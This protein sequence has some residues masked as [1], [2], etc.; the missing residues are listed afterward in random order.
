M[1]NV[2]ITGM[3]IVSSLGHDVETFFARMIAGDV[4]IEAAPWAS[5][6]GP[7]WWSAVRDFEP[8]RW[9]SPVVESGTDLYAQYTLAAA[10]QC[11]RASGVSLD[12]LRTAVVHGT[13]L[14]GVRAL[15]RAQ[16][17]LDRHGPA[18][19]DRK[20][21]IKI[22]PNMP[23]AQIAM[24]WDLHGPQL[25]I[26]TTCAS[27]LD[28]IGTAARLIADGRADVALAGG[29]EGGWAGADGRAQ[30]DFVPAVYHS[31]INY[32]M[33][34]PGVDRSVASVPFD[35]HRTGVVT[36]EGSAML[37][38][39][40]ADLARSRGAAI[41]AEIVGYGSVADA[42]HPSSPEPSGRWE[43]E[44]MRQAL[45]DAELEPGAVGA[46]IAHATSTRKGDLAEIRAINA[47]H[48]RAA[49]AVMSVKGHIGHSGAAAGAMSSIVAV[50][51]MAR[52]VLPHT[53]GTREVDGEA[54][55]TVV[56]ERPIARDAP[57]V[58][59]NAFGF[60]GQNASV[61]L[62]RPGRTG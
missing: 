49:L 34:T 8:A 56:T 41:L 16:H 14:G 19:I 22:S 55:F 47:V 31:Q 39:E 3:G 23:A 61:I 40:R 2:A 45:Q 43:A 18:A 53:A 24:R 30:G 46:V 1:R 15:M 42:H 52:G 11:V 25:T 32:G 6:A 35:R 62:A 50:L 12:P 48:G 9:M 5:P 10:E 21:L 26:C 7:V 59:V 28:A 38:L 29:T 58:Q 51:A 37:V 20:T 27:S 17:E 4:A 36:G 60:G 44:T 54:R 33:I 13:T 57:L